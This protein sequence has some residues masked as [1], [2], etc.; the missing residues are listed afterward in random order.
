MVRGTNVI[1]TCEDASHLGGPMGSEYTTLVFT[2]VYSSVEVAQKKAE[3]YQHGFPEWA[4]WK[5][6]DKKMWCDSGAYIWTIQPAI[7]EE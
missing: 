7:S 6:N 2:K 4:R 1:L 5:E 3:E